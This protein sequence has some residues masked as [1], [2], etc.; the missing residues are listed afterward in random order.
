M[1]YTWIK[2]AVFD[3]SARQLKLSL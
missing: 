1:R 3:D 2:H